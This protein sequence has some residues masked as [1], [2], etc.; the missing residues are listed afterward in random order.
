MN[1]QYHVLKSVSDTDHIL[2]LMDDCNL[3]N[4]EPRMGACE[5]NLRHETMYEYCKAH[6]PK[7]YEN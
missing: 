4:D 6:I 5:C 2:R 7:F 1:S 3:K